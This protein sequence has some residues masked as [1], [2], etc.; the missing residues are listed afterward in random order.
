[1][2]QK[3]TIQL[4]R[5]TNVSAAKE[6]AAQLAGKQAP[7]KEKTWTQTFAASGAKTGGKQ[8]G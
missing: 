5:Q 4:N 6:T 1:M 8:S 3:Y 2:A 7:S